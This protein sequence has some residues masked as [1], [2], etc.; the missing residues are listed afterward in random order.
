MEERLR[1]DAAFGWLRFFDWSI[2]GL[3]AAFAALS[4]LSIQ[5]ANP[6]YGEP[7]KQLLWYAV[8]FFLFA[9]VQAADARLVQNIAPILY[10]L[11]LVLLVLVLFFGQETN[12]ARSW[13]QFG[14][15][16]FQPA[17]MAKVATILMAARWFQEREEAERPPERFGEL[18]PFFALVA[19]PAFLILIEPD[20]GD[21]VVLAVVLVAMLA[22]AGRLRHAAGVLGLYGLG[23]A[24]LAALYRFWPAVFFKLI[25]E[26]QWRRITA[27]LADPPNPA[28]PSQYQVYMSLQ[29]I[30]SGQ[31]FGKAGSGGTLLTELRLVPEAQTDFIF[32]VIGERFGFLGAATV[33]LLYFFLLY[34]LVQ[35][36][37]QVR[38][39]FERATVAGL[40]GM[41]TFQIFENIGMTVK[42]TPITG[43]TLPFISYGGSS[44][45]TN[46]IALGLVVSFGW[47]SAR[48]A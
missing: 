13:F 11:S 2:V 17:E 40:V 19:A 33:L 7:V 21:A 24:L 15:F 18:W 10:G 9:A 38:T 1:R 37:M 14:A 6:L 20:L 26:Y 8:G 12:G 36:G 31:M 3:I 30:G 27:V 43:I 44:L 29:A 25:K 16:K 47:R 41:W 48:A 39:T 5:G 45:T 32:A 4:Y 46:L 22:V 23:I 28:D 35:I 42:L 34:R